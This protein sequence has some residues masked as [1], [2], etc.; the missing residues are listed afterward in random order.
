MIKQYPSFMLLP[1]FT[2]GMYDG[3][4]PCNFASAL[5]FLIYLS[6]IGKTQRRIFWLGSLF[7]MI[8][9]A[10]NVAL[11]F[12]VFDSLMVMPFADKVVTIGYWAFTA[13]FFSFGFFDILDWGR[14]KKSSDTALFRR[15]LPAFLDELYPIES[16][17]VKKRI[18]FG[19]IGVLV[20]ILIAFGV[21]LAASIF[22]QR[23]YV[24]IVH[25]FYI[26]GGDVLFAFWSFFQYSVALTLPL[27]AIW[28]IVLFL[29]RVGRTNAKV[30]SYYK[31]I[32]SA[33]YLAVGVGLGYFGG[34]Y[35]FLKC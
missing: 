30:I 11:A 2:V 32:S 6:I 21:T 3:V 24:F 20:T 27:I 31:G 1:A 9:V 16:I 35:F 26:A 13:A 7:L 23:E 12:G 25:S 5:V 29:G 17:S 8:I 34:G 18:L 33:L 15:K 22:P 14:Y 10:T 4:N 28:V 19:A